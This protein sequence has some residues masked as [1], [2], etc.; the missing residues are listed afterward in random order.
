MHKY[1]EHVEGIKNSPVLLLLLATVMTTGL[2]QMSPSL[3]ANM[4]ILFQPE[5]FIIQKLSSRRSVSRI[6]LHNL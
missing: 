6:K 5:P 1:Q 4:G 2:P 3:L